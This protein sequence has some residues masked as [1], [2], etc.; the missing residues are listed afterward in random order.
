MIQHSNSFS[1]AHQQ[2]Q[3]LQMPSNLAH[4]SVKESAQPAWQCAPKTRGPHP[5]EKMQLEGHTN[6]KE[7]YHHYEGNSFIRPSACQLSGLV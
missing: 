2:I 5:A 6:P 7:N 4:S 1:K 3:Y